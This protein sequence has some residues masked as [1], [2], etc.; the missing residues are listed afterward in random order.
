MF[1]LVSTKFGPKLNGVPYITISTLSLA[2]VPIALPLFFISFSG[3]VNKWAI[4]NIRY[5]L[6]LFGLVALATI[7]SYFIQPSFLVFMLL[8]A[9][10]LVIITIAIMDKTFRGNRKGF[11]LS[12][13]GFLT[14]SALL[15]LT[16]VIWMKPYVRV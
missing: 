14:A 1:L 6:K 3:L 11:L 13:N 4:G 7:S 16:N 8:G 15:V 10:F 5:I 9:G 2:V 12:I